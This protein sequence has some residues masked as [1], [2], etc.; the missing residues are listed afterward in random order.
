MSALLAWLYLAGYLAGVLFIPFI[1]M[2]RKSAVAT[3]AWILS[4]LF[5]PFL[6][7][8][9]YIWLGKARIERRVTRRKL[10]NARI[11]EHLQEMRSR[12]AP[13]QLLAE[14]HPRLPVQEDLVRATNALGSFPITTGNRVTLLTEPNAS[15][16]ALEEAMERAERFLHL[17]FYIFTPDDT[18][19]RIGDLLIAAAKRGVECRLLIDSLGSWSFDRKFHRLLH[20]AGVHVARFFPLQ[21]SLPTKGWHLNL[22]NHRKI[23][24]MDGHTAFIG[25]SNIANEYRFRRNRGS[26]YYDTQLKIEGPAVSHLHEVFAEDWFFATKEDLTEEDYFPVQDALGA[27]ALQIVPSGPDQDT[28]VIREVICAAIHCARSSVHIMSPY[29]VPDAPLLSALTAAAIRGHSVQVLVPAKTDWATVQAASRS[30]YEELLR[31]GVQIAEYP[32]GLLHTKAIIVD[33][34]WA[35][36]GSANFDPRSFDLNFEAN[37]NLYAPTTVRALSAHFQKYWHASSPV[38]LQHCQ[39]WSTA[40]CFLQNTARIFSPVL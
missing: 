20:N 19:R 9:L 30:Y 18:G 12:I 17:Q 10:S 11:A 38:T 15:F 36:L 14:D 1:I 32:H 25:S 33:D 16:A 21:F 13:F 5:L 40:Q 29:F 2:E 28:P 27:D 23:A 4:L 6:G 22:R 26:N 31:R 39:R 37:V 35:S 24:V 7:P 8:L 34:A 3:V